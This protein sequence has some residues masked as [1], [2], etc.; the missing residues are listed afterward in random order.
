MHA[1]CATRLRCGCGGVLPV[2]APGA[3]LCAQFA[4]WRIA[5][6]MW[7]SSVGA[8]VIAAPASFSPFAGIIG[9]LM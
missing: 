6:S 1:A 5:W 8:W 7:A 4:T 3:L 2:T 9:M